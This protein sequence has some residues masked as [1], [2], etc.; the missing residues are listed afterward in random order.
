MK[1]W[2]R[3]PAQNF[4]GSLQSFQSVAVVKSFMNP[5][6]FLHIVERLEGFLSKLPAS[7]QKPVLQE[8]TPLKELFL[9]QRAPR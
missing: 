3:F 9:K 7:I 4:A 8:L 5:P 6:M 2:K 1:V